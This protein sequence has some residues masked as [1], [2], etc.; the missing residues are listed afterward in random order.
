MIGDLL[1][2]L[3]TIVVGLGGG[4]LALCRWY[5]LRT[6]RRARPAEAAQLEGE[7]YV[8]T[9]EGSD[10]RSSGWI[11]ATWPEVSAWA[12]EQSLR[13]DVDRVDVEHQ[14]PDRPGYVTMWTWDEGR[15]AGVEHRKGLLAVRAY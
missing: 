8:V 5:D 3:G 10:W 14:T 12:A 1:L 11:I 2:A 6:Q 15:E 13:R 7:E 4:T 9:V